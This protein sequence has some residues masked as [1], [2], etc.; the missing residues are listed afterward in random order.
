MLQRLSHELS[1]RKALE[2]QLRELGK[3]KAGA[4]SDAERARRKLDELQGQLGSLQDAA[5][6]LQVR[7]TTDT[8]CWCL[9]LL[10][11]NARKQR[12][13]TSIHCC[14][15]DGANVPGHQR[16]IIDVQS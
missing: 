11:S 6:P 5:K 3:A 10:L 15:T 7:G 8:S 14:C 9:C 1:C 4:H 16:C 2:A 12:M 13:N